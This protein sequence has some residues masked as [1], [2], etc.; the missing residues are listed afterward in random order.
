MN[1][2]VLRHSLQSGLE[3]LEAE[4]ALRSDDATIERLLRY[5]LL[6]EKW[7]AVYNLTALKDPAE[8]LSRHLL[9]SLVLN[10][11]LTPGKNCQPDN[12]HQPPT[13]DL[14]D[15]GSGAGLPVLPLAITRP[16]MNFASV[17]SN[18]KKT[19][20]QQQVVIELGLE[21]IQIF[22]E[23][24][25]NITLRAH[26]ITS[27]AFSAPA[28]FLELAERLCHDNARVALMLGHADKLPDPLPEPF[29]LEQLVQVDIPG[30]QSPRHVA[31]CRR[32]QLNGLHLH[33]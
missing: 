30:T 32:R 24:V 8:M 7:N 28:Q 5:L 25:Q 16:E 17:E 26:W 23:R 2:A 3:K 20:F 22:Q 18:G 11:W 21:N 9:D 4:Q 33:S 29:I 12:S 1:T 14:V 15:V 19:R 6:L 27:R 31:L 13:V 10:R